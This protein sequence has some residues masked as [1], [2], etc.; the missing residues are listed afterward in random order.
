MKKLAPFIIILFTTIE[1]CAQIIGSGFIGYGSYKMSEMKTYMAAYQMRYDVSVRPVTS[2]SFPSYWNGGFDLRFPTGKWQSGTVITFGS[3][4]SQAYY[5]DY[6]GHI[7]LDMLSSFIH[8]GIVVNRTWSLKNNSWTIGA[9]LRP[10]VGLG[11]TI[12]R[13]YSEI[14]G[15]FNQSFYQSS[16][17]YQSINVSLQPTISVSRTI[18]KFYLSAF[19]GYQ[20]DVVKGKAKDKLGP[21]LKMDWSGYRLGLSAGVKFKDP[22]GE[23]ANTVLYIGPGLGI[24]YGGAGLQMSVLAHRSVGFFGGVGYNLHKIA[25]NGGIRVMVLRKGYARPYV[26]GMYG[27]NAVVIVND[28][29]DLSRTFNGPSVGIG[30]DF[31]QVDRTYTFALIIPFRSDEVGDYVNA[32]GSQGILLKPGFLPFTI[33]GGWRFQLN[34]KT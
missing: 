11:K 13:E 27:Y 14:K 4:G 2:Y 15:D 21:E 31:G 12:L 30:A 6:S 22:E 25:A 1:S 10:G 32:L 20:A 33:S 26:T 9:D 17:T 8:V 19:A 16:A 24:D 34:K 5:S 28:K 7:G 18:G 3:T 23:D 29:R